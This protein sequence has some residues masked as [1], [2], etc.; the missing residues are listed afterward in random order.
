MQSQKT[1]RVL[2]GGTLRICMFGQSLIGASP[3]ARIPRNFKM[4]RSIF[5]TELP[6]RSPAGFLSWHNAHSLVA[7]LVTLVVRVHSGL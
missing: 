3:V 4:E 1:S 7:A 5:S 2:A 6:G